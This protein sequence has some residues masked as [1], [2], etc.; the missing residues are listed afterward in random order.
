[1]DKQHK[2]N[3][4]PFE[5]DTHKDTQI[6]NTVIMEGDTRDYTRFLI[7]GVLKTILLQSGIWQSCH[8]PVRGGVAREEGM[9]M[10]KEGDYDGH[11][12][13]V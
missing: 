6:N 11:E 13:V 1:M 4:K 9:V 8:P 7:Q 10:E 3:M 12:A 5:M 2:N